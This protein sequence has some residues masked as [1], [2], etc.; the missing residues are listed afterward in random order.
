VGTDS[1]TP[2]DKDLLPSPP[3]DSHDFSL[4]GTLYHV[5]FPTSP[6]SAVSLADHRDNSATQ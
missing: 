5:Q 6:F 3:L 4:L 1:A 2:A